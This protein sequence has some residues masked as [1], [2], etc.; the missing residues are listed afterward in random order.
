MNIVEQLKSE[1]KKNYVQ[2][3][4]CT[5]R[6]E[7]YTN[8][9]RSQVVTLL[10]KERF[11]SGKDVSRF[12]SFSPIGAIFKHFNYENVLRKNTELDIGTIAIEDL[13]NHEDI[14]VPYLVF[15]ASHLSITA[16]YIEI[17]ELLVKTAQY[18]DTLENDLF[19]KDTH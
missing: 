12:I 13:K 1:F 7:L 17:Y 4:E 16:D 15:R 8:S 9:N 5:W 11:E 2:D 18:A 14:K 19:A 10:Y 6:F 3:D